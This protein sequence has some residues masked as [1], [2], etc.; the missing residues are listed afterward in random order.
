VLG[1]VHYPTSH[2]YDDALNRDEYIGRSGGTTY[3]ADEKRIYIVRAN[4]EVIAGNDSFWS[5]DNEAIE[6]NPGD[7]VIVPLDAERIKPLT[8]WT[9]VTQIIYQVGIAVAAFTSAGIF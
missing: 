2:L 9:N 4:G 7:T 1:E 8:L 6:I 5:F 3:K